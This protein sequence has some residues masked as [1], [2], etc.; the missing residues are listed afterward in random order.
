[1]RYTIENKTVVNVGRV[2]KKNNHFVLPFV[3]RAACFN[4]AHIC[5]YATRRQHKLPCMWASH[6]GPAKHVGPY[7]QFRSNM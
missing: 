6:V 2:N 1:M 5:G 7:Y 3:S 4:S